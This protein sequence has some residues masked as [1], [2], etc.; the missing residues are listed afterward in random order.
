MAEL[1]VNWPSV[2][3]SGL[4][5]KVVNSSSELTERDLQ[6]ECVDQN[7]SGLSA[8]HYNDANAFYI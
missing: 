2:G 4:F 5:L 3:Y 7:S 1:S 8:G 6:G